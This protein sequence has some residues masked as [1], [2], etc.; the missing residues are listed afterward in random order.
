MRRPHLLLGIRMAAS[1]VLA[2]LFAMTVEA[3]VIIL[4]SDE[5]Y[6]SIMVLFAIV[7]AAVIE[8]MM[9]AHARTLATRFR[10]G[11]HSGPQ[12]H[13]GMVRH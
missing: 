5:G 12:P 4:S 8:S 2:A 13:A 9:A 7:C 6:P 10:G 3:A 1:T 11:P